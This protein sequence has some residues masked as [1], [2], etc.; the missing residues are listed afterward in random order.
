[1]LYPNG[2]FAAAGGTAEE[3]LGI[4]RRIKDSAL[5]LSKIHGTRLAERKGFV[6]RY[7]V[8]RTLT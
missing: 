1:M 3:S 4:K 2:G 7:K 8:L 5:V 6:N